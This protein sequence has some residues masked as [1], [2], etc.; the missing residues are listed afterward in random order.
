LAEEEEER[1]FSAKLVTALDVDV[2][3]YFEVQQF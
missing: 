1:G 3:E 2:K